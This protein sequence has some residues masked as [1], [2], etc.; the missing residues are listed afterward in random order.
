[1]AGRRERAG[2][3]QGQGRLEA[4]ACSHSGPPGSRSD[5]HCHSDKNATRGRVLP[6]LKLPSE[7]VAYTR[8][9]P[10]ATTSEEIMHLHYQIPFQRCPVS[11]SLFLASC[12]PDGG[13]KKKSTLCEHRVNECKQYSLCDCSF[14]TDGLPA[15]LQVHPQSH[16]KSRSERVA[17][18]SHFIAILHT[19]FPSQLEFI[20]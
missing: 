10:H 20:Y 19:L 7:Y 3:G 16:G 9:C 18:C 5:G 11:A 6:G 12:P 15:T 4:R 8:D 17:P 2:R 1:M 14:C 13:K